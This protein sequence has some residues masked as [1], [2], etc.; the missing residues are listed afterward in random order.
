[1]VLNQTVGSDPNINHK[2][3]KAKLQVETIYDCLQSP[4]L[5]DT[6]GVVLIVV[7]GEGLTI[8]ARND[9]CVL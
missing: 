5:L 6:Q 2:L 3:L 8:G 4:I 7:L 1:M 9:S